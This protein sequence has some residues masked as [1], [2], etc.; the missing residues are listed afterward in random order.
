MAKKNKNKKRKRA[1][2]AVEGDDVV[3]SAPEELTP[4]KLL[5]VTKAA[6]KVTTTQPTTAPPD[7][8]KRRKKRK[9]KKQKRNDERNADGSPTVD[10]VKDLAS[11]VPTSKF[12]FLR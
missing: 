8:P 6:E 11:A 4:N 12:P 3:D 1:T 5:S 9:R 7:E 2:A 10:D